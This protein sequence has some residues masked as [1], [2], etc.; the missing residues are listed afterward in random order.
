MWS[1]T[2]GLCQPISYVRL[3]R[4]GHCTHYSREPMLLNATFWPL[5]SRRKQR[6]SSRGCCSCCSVWQQF[7]RGMICSST[8]GEEL[9]HRGK[10]GEII[11]EALAING[12]IQITTGIGIIKVEVNISSS[13]SGVHLFISDAEKSGERLSSGAC[14]HKLFHWSLIQRSNFL[15]RGE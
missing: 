15:S 12:H 6:D 2:V 7:F 3:S 1:S 4:L 5:Q 11:S 9:H 10:L 13:L 8:L 14:R